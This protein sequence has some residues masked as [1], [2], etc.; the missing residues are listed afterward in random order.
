MKFEPVMALG[1]PAAGCIELLPA[2]A[3][4]G[5]GLVLTGAADVGV[6]VDDG[7]DDGVD[8]VTDRT[9]ESI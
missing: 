8:D 5:C 7:V 1:A 2:T 4:D 3:L 6:D 9:V